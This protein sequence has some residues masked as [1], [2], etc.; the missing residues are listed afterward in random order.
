MKKTKQNK[1]KQNKTK[2]K[3]TQNKKTKKHHQNV[4]TQLC[5]LY[6]YAFSENTGT[7]TCIV[8]KFSFHL[9][10]KHGALAYR[11]FPYQLT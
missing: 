8:S 1:T 10:E 3:Q 6:S 2:Q 9:I 7:P 5:D 11:E 4:S